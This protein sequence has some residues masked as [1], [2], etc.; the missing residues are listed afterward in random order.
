MKNDT[1]KIVN[2]LKAALR[3]LIDFA[4]NRKYTTVFIISGLILMATLFK[5]RTYLNPPVNQERYEEGKLQINYE[6]LDQEIIDQISSTLDDKNIDVDP[7]FDEDREN[8][9]S[10]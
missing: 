4:K 8:P 9:F 3:K 7:I 2:S 10:E 1:E 6:T 5:S